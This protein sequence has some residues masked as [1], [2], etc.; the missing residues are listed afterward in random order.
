MIKTGGENVHSPE[1]EAAI[2]AH[3]AVLEGVVIGY[4]D[5]VWS[6]SI[7]AV[8][9][10]RSGTDVSAE[11]LIAWC[12]GR[13]THFKYPRSVVFTDS[14]PKGGTGKVQ[15]QVLRARYAVAAG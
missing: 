12:R 10:A 13:L 5:P 6:E 15:K 8:V 1:V 11:E 3:P 7:R 4:P 2:V 9:V 14:L